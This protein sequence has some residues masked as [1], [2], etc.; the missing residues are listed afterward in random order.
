M[1]NLSFSF[2][3]TVSY[4]MMLVQLSISDLQ[5]QQHFNTLVCHP[6]RFFAHF[7]VFLFDIK[8][9]VLFFLKLSVVSSNPVTLAFSHKCVL[10]SQTFMFKSGHLC[11]CSL[12]YQ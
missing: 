7:A 10:L 11:H 2:D 5:Q 3:F 8:N 9:E 12:A 1:P 4:T 6:E